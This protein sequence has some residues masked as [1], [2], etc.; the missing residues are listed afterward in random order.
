[1]AAKCL[2][3]LLF[4][5]VRVTRLLST[6]APAPGPNNVV[7]TDTPVLLNVN[8]N[9]L[10]GEE[11]TQKAGCDCIVSDYKGPDLLRRWDLEFDDAKIDPA[12]AEMLTGA[13]A[14]L[15]SADPIGN[16]WPVN[17]YDCGGLPQPY[18]C[19]EGWTK[20]WTQSAQ[21]PTWPWIHW[22]WPS[23]SWSFGPSTLS[24]DHK[25][26]RYNGFSRTNTVWGTGPYGD[27]PEAAHALGGRFF[28]AVE[29]PA[30]ACG[31][32]SNGVT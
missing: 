13:P 17:Q 29:P 21:D 12:L 1:M 31:Y 3:S 15:S 25:T 5:R 16:W 6:G 14:I 18:V 23:T 10:A 9:Y 20:G 24:S 4:C 11:K 8:P 22:I 27:L 26:D 32:G 30:A 2:G 28:T 7:V 19:F